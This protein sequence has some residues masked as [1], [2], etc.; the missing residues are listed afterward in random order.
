MTET[1]DQREKT[2]KGSG[3]DG[4]GRGT[5]CEQDV[6]TATE[7][8]ETEPASSQPAGQAVGQAVGSTQTA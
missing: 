8:E 4:T 6:G 2:W 3:R 1:V 5:C 7:R